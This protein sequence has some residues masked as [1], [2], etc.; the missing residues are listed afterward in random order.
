MASDI[1]LF[2]GSSTLKEIEGLGPLRGIPKAYLTEE[3]AGIRIDTDEN[4]TIIDSR[5]T[6]NRSLLAAIRGSILAEEFSYFR[7]EDTSYCFNACVNEDNRFDSI[8]LD[9]LSRIIGK[10]KLNNILNFVPANFERM[11]STLIKYNFPFDGKE[12]IHEIKRGTIKSN[13]C[14][15]DILN[16][17]KVL[18][19]IIDASE[20][21]FPHS[22]SEA[23]G[24]L[25]EHFG[26][27]SEIFRPLEDTFLEHYDSTQAR[28]VSYLSINSIGIYI[29][30]KKKGNNNLNMNFSVSIGN[31]LEGDIK[32]IEKKTNV[33]AVMQFKKCQRGIDNTQYTREMLEKLK[34]KQEIF[35]LKDKLPFLYKPCDA[36]IIHMYDDIQCAVPKHFEYRKEVLELHS[37]AQ[38]RRTFIDRHGLPSDN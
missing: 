10:N 31:E 22:I 34:G 35:T 23:K 28:A 36:S 9:K 20:Y 32:N 4:D 5:N 17:N 16:K 38:K 19:A 26:S 25:R 3:Y 24:F 37:Q 12:I 2:E 27:F 1:I 33:Y 8:D 11:L 30:S 29:L 7:D 14:I 13:S 15:E 6:G 21:G 18:S